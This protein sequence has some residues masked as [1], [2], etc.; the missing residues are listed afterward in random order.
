MSPLNE[1]S[2]IDANTSS[3][4]LQKKSLLSRPFLVICRIEFYYNLVLRNS[5]LSTRAASTNHNQPQTPLLAITHRN[6]HWM[7]DGLLLL[8]EF[9]MLPAA[10]NACF[11][12]IFSIE[13]SCCKIM[14]L[15]SRRSGVHFLQQDKRQY[16]VY[17]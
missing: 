10:S 1:W 15:N 17:H 8:I 7:L 14:L 5:T 16:R 4:C 9:H 6:H 12:I 13:L 3:F 2:L 11:A